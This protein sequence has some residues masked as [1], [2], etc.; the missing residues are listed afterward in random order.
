M[1]DSTAAP[2]VNALSAPLVRRLV[3][4]AAALRLG[5]SRDASGAR[6]VD[7]G[8]LRPRSQGEAV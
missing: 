2:S 7:A 3:E 1:G 8:S 5:V 6:L 4:D